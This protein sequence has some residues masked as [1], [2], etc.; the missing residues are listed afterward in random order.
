V[1]GRVG[2]SVMPIRVGRTGE[3]LPASDEAHCSCAV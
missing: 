1:L 3:C 2:L